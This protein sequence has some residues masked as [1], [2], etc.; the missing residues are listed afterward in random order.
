LSVHARHAATAAQ[1]SQH[2]FVEAAGA[3]APRSYLEGTVALGKGSLA[4]RGAASAGPASRKPASLYSRAALAV[5]VTLAFSGVTLPAQHWPR[6][7]REVPG[8]PARSFHSH[9]SPPW[10]KVP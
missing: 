8:A 6:R 7:P 1:R 4:Q 3:G 5:L 9:S 2:A 10:S